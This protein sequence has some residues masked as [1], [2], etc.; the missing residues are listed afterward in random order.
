M[1]S[2]GV[3]TEGKAKITSEK[4]EVLHE[5][6]QKRAGTRGKKVGERDS[7]V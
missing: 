1:A 6:T 7:M 3:G 5:E 4:K 2:P